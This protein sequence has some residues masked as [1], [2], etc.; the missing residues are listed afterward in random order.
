[1][2]QNH[3]LTNVLFQHQNIK[4]YL[5]I[6]IDSSPVHNISSAGKFAPAKSDGKLSNVHF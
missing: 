3:D 1:M 2:E 6:R 4:N 5:K